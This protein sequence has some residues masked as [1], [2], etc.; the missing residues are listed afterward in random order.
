MTIIC[1]NFVWVDTN[2]EGKFANGGFPFLIA[3]SL[4][5]F[6]YFFLKWKV[7]EFSED[8]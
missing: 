1:D 8:I 4:N 6:D 5:F 3:A 7:P 2:S